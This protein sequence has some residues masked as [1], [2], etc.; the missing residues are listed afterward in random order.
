MH[1]NL[2]QLNRENMIQP[3]QVLLEIDTNKL[4]QF[5][6]L[7]ETSEYGF[8]INDFC[9]PA[10]ICDYSLY[11]MK[12]LEYKKILQ[13]YSDRII[14]L[15]GAFFS[16]IIHSNDPDIAQISKNKIIRSIQT[17]TE[18]NCSKVI[19][20]TGII[21]QAVGHMLTDIAKVH[22]S[23]WGEM[24]EKY[25]D[26]EICIENVWEKNTEFFEILLQN[27][28]N[29]RFTM[30][31]DNGHANVYSSTPIPEWINKL[32]KYLSHVHLSD[33]DA[34]TDQHLGLGTGRLDIKNEINE[35]IKIKENITYKLEVHSYEGINDCLNFMFNNNLLRNHLS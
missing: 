6:H 9:Y 30:C 16:L 34:I 14:T 18:L 24:L 1:S 8:E 31:I 5:E 12:L 27:V 4:P 15:H 20:H 19:F 7:L 11:K 10:I 2:K 21:P 17:A 26:I 35:F 32:Q 29:P 23:F 3:K 13:K 28:N 22:T 25:K 33:N